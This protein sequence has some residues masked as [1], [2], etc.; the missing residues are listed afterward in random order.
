M[1]NNFLLNKTSSI[2]NVVGLLYSIGEKKEPLLINI[3]D[4][5]FYQHFNIANP[6]KIGDV[7]EYIN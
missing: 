1:S 2:Q 4:E 6:Q 3:D 7:G 5:T